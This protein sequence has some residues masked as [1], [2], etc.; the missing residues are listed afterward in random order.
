MGSE[1]A[2]LV[3]VV[4]V[5]KSIRLE[6]FKAAFKPEPVEVGSFT[7]LIG[8]NGSGKST[9]LEAMQWI[10]AT[11]RRDAVE[12]CKR[13]FGVHDLI[14]LRSRAK[15]QFFALSTSW[16]VNGQPWDYSIRVEQD[17]D[18][19]TPRIA[20]EQ[21]VS[22]SGRGRS[23]EIDKPE[24]SDRLALWR[25]TTAVAS[26]IRDYW[27][28][29]TFLRLSPGRLA[30][31]SL[32]RRASSD[33]LLDEEGQS[34][35]ALLNELNADQRKWLIDQ[36]NSVLRDIE[37]VSVSSSGA[38]RSEKVH[39]SLHERMPYRGRHGRS[40]FPI[41]AWMLSEGTRRLTAIFGLLA[42]DP[43]PSLLCIEEVENGLDPWAVKIVLQ[44]L[45]S[46]ADKGTQVIVTTHS[47]WLLDHVA[48]ESVIRVRRVQ[49]ET[50]YERFADQAA[51]KEYADDVPVGTRYVQES[52]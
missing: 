39:Y 41:P 28:R 17:E 22:G 34:L 2:Q 50:Q 36:V 18:G 46:A 19:G 45:Q 51:F 49:G 1:T 25:S 6:R 52:G 7:T 38:N 23:I 15:R 29:A 37:S 32:A 4:P 44:H 9:L 14:N 12:A 5:L 8:R 10:D 31:G 24:S 40:L 21:L 30:E 48:P 42:H 27:K 11:L 33:P 13:Y 20:T 3:S 16:Q 35:P 47:P 43:A 26:A